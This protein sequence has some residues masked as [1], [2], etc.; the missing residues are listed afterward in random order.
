[1]YKFLIIILLFN[2]AD[3][4]IKFNLDINPAIQYDCLPFSGCTQDGNKLNW[5][6]VS[7]ECISNTTEPSGIIFEPQN[8]NNIEIGQIFS[9]GKLFSKNVVINSDPGAPQKFDLDLI[10]SISNDQTS[11]IITK[12]LTIE[13]EIEETSNSEPCL[14][15]SIEPCADRHVLI[16]PQDFTFTLG[17]NQ[18]QLNFVNNGIIENILQ[19]TCNS[20]FPS[21]F[22]NLDV[23][24]FCINCCDFIFLGKRQKSMYCPWNFRIYYNNVIFPEKH[25]TSMN[26]TFYTDD[27]KRFSYNPPE[28][29]NLVFMINTD[30][31]P[32]NVGTVYNNYKW[33][34]NRILPGVYLLKFETAEITCLTNNRIQ[35]YTRDLAPPP[36]SCID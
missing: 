4:Q 11:D 21:E 5:G 3:A 34:P 23:Q 30:I 10:L 36:N 18:Y 31:L 1:M 35:I 7:D 19:E 6:S 32:L 22:K 25:I 26:L 24:I 14:Y 9:L 13:F 8:T 29:K 16:I 28:L 33:R 20:E 17:K 2:L 27:P 15:P 12:P